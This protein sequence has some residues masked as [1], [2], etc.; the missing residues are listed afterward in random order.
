MEL[1]QT[2]KLLED[3]EILKAIYTAMAIPKKTL[4]ARMFPDVSR[5]AIDN[6]LYSN[7]SMGSRFKSVLLEKFPNINPKFLN[8]GKGEP[9]LDEMDTGMVNDI[10]KGLDGMPIGLLK[11]PAQIEELRRQNEQIL[12]NQQLIL[13]L[14]QKKD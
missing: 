6:V 5:S 7:A 3:K 9:L 12:T 10:M 11:L 8:F 14:L 2:K 1:E 4:A 13:D